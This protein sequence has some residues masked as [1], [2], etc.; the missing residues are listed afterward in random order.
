MSDAPKKEEVRVMLTEDL[1]SSV[2]HQAFQ[3][4]VRSMGTNT[5]AARVMGVGIDRK[6]VV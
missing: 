6:S 3:W 2:G 1:F 4:L 5:E